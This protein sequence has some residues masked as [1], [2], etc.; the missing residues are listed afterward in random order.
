MRGWG[1]DI[2]MGIKQRVVSSRPTQAI[3]QW[4]LVKVIRV[5]ATKVN[6]TIRRM[7]GLID[8]GGSLTFIHG[9]WAR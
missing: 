1:G 7:W 8:K 4:E 5:P 6:S 3:S 2:I 9:V